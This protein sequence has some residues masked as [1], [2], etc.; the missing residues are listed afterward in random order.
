MGV[1]VFNFN[2][3]DIAS[4]A[5]VHDGIIIGQLA[6]KKLCH[7]GAG[8]GGI[9]IK[10]CKRYVE[11]NAGLNEHSSQLPASEDAYLK[12]LLE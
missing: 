8:S 11:I 7:S 5:K 1:D 6:R 3:N 12:I 10:D 4:G 2:G 9:R